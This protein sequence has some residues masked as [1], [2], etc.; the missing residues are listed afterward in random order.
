[1]A[2]GFSRMGSNVPNT[3][4][5]T[6]TFRLLQSQTQDGIQIQIHFPFKEFEIFR[7]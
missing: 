4:T 3:F 7:F 5:P 2:I 1:M 6:I